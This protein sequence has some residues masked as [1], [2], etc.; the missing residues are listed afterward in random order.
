MDMAMIVAMV[1]VEEAMAVGEVWFV[2]MQDPLFA[3]GRRTVAA[4]MG[5]KRNVVSTMASLGHF[6]L[7]CRS[8]RK[9][10]QGNLAQEE[11]TLMLI[12]WEKFDLNSNPRVSE[13]HLKPISLN[14]VSTAVTEA[15]RGLSACRSW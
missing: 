14:R 9:S 15:A 1:V 5:Q 3:K 7:E 4:Q 2:M 8:N 12:E 13:N 10:A 6:A 11:S